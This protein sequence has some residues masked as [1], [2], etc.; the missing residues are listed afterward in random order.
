MED[1]YNEIVEKKFNCKE[2]NKTIMIL[3]MKTGYSGTYPPV[4]CQ[5]CYS[6]L[7]AD[8][9]TSHMTERVATREL[10]KYQQSEVCK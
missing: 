2:C 4:Y 1:D 6:D 9:V 8:L 3:F 10:L 7:S 5:Q